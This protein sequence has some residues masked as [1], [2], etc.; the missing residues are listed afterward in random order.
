MAI[1]A[2]TGGTTNL[3]LVAPEYGFGN[4]IV[5]ILS[6]HN[7][8]YTWEG[9]D[10]VY[11][12]RVGFGFVQVVY[13]GSGND[14]FFGGSSFDRCYD[15]DGNDI[16]LL[17][18]EDDEAFVGYGNDIYSG[19]A[20]SDMLRFDQ[21]YR[22]GTTVVPNTVGV[23]VDLAVTSAQNIGVLGSDQFNGFE[24]VFGS[25]AA[26]R[27]Y[28]NNLTNRL[29]GYRGNDYLDGRAGDDSLEGSEGADT[30]IG[31]SG[32]DTFDVF[33]TVAR[34]DTIRF[35]ALSD[36]P[37]SAIEPDRIYHFD[38]GGL[39]NDDRID[40]SP[41]DANPV[42]AGNQAFVFRGSGAFTAVRG[43]VR[44]ETVG[45][46]TFVYVDNDTD[47]APEMVIRVAG[48]T[49]LAAGDFIL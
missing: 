11:S 39:A 20:G 40:L 4:D 37:A 43:E 45:T 15:G 24:H 16:C 17:G 46:E 12:T 48:V 3:A 14:T 38:K 44:V 21:V 19:G 47:P 27:I 26:D 13:L 30:L 28:G 42:L 41:I 25:L 34:R 7:T 29:L 35:N 32:I 9:S 1:L 10:T 33:E 22:D 8:I 36:S 5:G 23:A 6:G 2:V 31:G 18:A 49:G